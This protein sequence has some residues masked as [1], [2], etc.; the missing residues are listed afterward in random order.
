V[1][2]PP[3]PDYLLELAANGPSTKREHY[4]PAEWDGSLPAGA[5]RLIRTSREVRER[6]RRVPGKH[7]DRTPSGVDASLASMLAH[8]GLAGSEVE[9]TLRASRA[10]A[11]L[12]RRPDSY[13]AA[14][15]GK[16][17]GWSR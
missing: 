1:P 7:A 12:P 8:N 17:L 11:G 4:A 16:A 2:L 15:V 9:A 13:F 14:T 10:R 3:C 6:F 5:A